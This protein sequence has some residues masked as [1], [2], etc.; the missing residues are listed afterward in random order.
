M[1]MM[2]QEGFGR[3][4]S[5]RKR[6]FVPPPPLALPYVDALDQMRFSNAWWRGIAALALTSLAIIVAGP[7]RGLPTVASA[8]P[9]DEAAIQYRA[10]GVR[11]LDAGGQ[12]G[13]RM[14][15]D[16]RVETIAVVPERPWR[17]LVA[18]LGEGDSLEAGLRR[19]GVAEIDA[20]AA[21]AAVRAAAPG[22]LPAGTKVNIRLGQAGLSGARPLETL[23]LKARF[24]L[25][26]A[27]ERNGDTFSVRKERIAVASEPMRIAGAVDQGLYWSLRAAG[28][29]PR[30]A[31]D[32]LK[33]IGAKIDVGTVLRG[34]RFDLVLERRVSDAGEELPG[35]LLFAGVTRQGMDPMALVKWRVAGDDQWIDPTGNAVIEE[36]GLSWPVDAPISSNFGMRV[37]PILRYKRLHG[38]IDFRTGHGAPV[39]A[40]ADGRVTRSGWNGGAGKQ[41]KLAHAEGVGT[42][43]SHLSRIVVPNGA[44]VNRGDLIGY[45]G[46]TG[47][48]TGPHLHYE[49]TLSG[50]KVDPHTV[51]TVRRQ[52]IDPQVLVAAQQ[53]YRSFQQLAPVA[54]P[55]P[56]PTS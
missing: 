1:D 14:A 26:V 29:S 54:R 39:Y 22:D 28:A 31:S 20:G 35:P 15:A 56:L 27:L 37:H 9:V 46:S 38:G 18:T 43:Y 17:E 44:S 5:L 25:R 36:E 32:Y 24:N 11:A 45:T 23:N 2:A 8:L 48:S 6:A 3:L 33:A 47:L 40:A 34:D 16:D 13:L 52:L 42:S 4:R 49:V 51:K 21:A 55:A 7:A 19:A 30:T 12:T 50:R 10:A 41:V 53:R